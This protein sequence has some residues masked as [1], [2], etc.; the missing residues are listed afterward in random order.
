MKRDP[1]P[2]TR[3]DASLAHAMAKCGIAKQHAHDVA[4]VGQA[5]GAPRKALNPRLPHYALTKLWP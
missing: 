1:L 4:R 5:T 3:N 2:V